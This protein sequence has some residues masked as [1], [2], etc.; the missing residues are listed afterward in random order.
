MIKTEE[1]LYNILGNLD[2]F[3]NYINTI[4]ETTTQRC[5]LAIP[6]L[7]M[8]HI[9]KEKEYNKI[10]EDFFQANPELLKHK[11]ILGQEINKIAAKN[12][13]WDIEKIFTQAGINA[14]VVIRNLNQEK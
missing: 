1:E 4:I 5:M 13:N 8:H 12:S 2:E 14:K 10:K 11:D 7:V 6:T 3:N 9:Q